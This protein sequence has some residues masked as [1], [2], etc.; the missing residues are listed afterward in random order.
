MMP[1]EFNLG[2]QP[3]DGILVERAIPN[4][5]LVN[6]STEQITH[7]MVQKARK[8][9]RL[10]TR[11][12]LKILHALNALLPEETPRYALKDLFNY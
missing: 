5:D 6:I 12:Q 10:T 8:G 1:K 9:R 4:H 11:V 2:E 3:L 7:K